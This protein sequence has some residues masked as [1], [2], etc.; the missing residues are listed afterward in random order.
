[1]V[2]VKRCTKQTRHGVAFF[3]CVANALCYA[4]RM[5]IGIAVPHF[6]DSKG[7]R[8]IVLSAF[9]Y[10]Y[11]CTQIPS[12]L[13][14]SRVGVKTVLATGVLVWTIFDAATILVASFKQLPLLILVRAGMGCGQGVIMSCLHIFAANWFPEK[15]QTT[16]VAI[17]SSGTDLGTILALLVSP[18]L[19][20]SSHGKWQVIFIFFSIASMIWLVFYMRHVTSTPEEHPRISKQ[21]RD[22]ILSSR[23]QRNSPRKKEDKAIPWR[24]LLTNRYL[25][26]IYI[27][28]FSANYSWYVLLGWLPTYL[29]ERLGLNLQENQLLAATPYMCG[30]VGLLVAGRA[31]DYLIT[32]QGVRT[33]YVRRCMSTIGSLIP[34]LLLY[35]LPYYS[36]T[37]M[38]AIGLLSGC[39]FFGRACTSGFWINMID[40][41]GAD[42]AGSIMGVSNSIGTVPGILGNMVTG[43]ILQQT[44]SWTTVFHLAAFVCAVGGIVFACGST[45]RN[46]FQQYEKRET[47]DDDYEAD[48]LLA[49]PTS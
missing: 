18:G 44:Q 40:V 16:L 47:E 39:L 11:I 49:K 24:I 1:M 28:H 30:Y 37:P 31:S 8:G 5:N 13:W 38:A 48:P 12:G 35:L 45:D 41:G 9:F 34:A 23:Q 29:H 32:V 36:E 14:A 27:A 2:L 33:L 6:I 15:E 17:V 7:D 42:Y 46:V 22:M 20:K 4:C 25:W 19:I 3:L 21:E 43:Y 10:G 26:V